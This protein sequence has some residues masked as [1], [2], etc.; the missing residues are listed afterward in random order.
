VFVPRG[1]DVPS[2]DQDKLWD[3]TPLKNLKPGQLL[4]GGDMLGSTFENDLF[5]EHRIMVSPKITGRIVEV[6]PAG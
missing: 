1:V 6:M 3:Y 4:V 5:S 2:L